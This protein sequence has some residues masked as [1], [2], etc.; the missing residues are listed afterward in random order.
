MDYYGIQEKINKEGNEKSFKYLG[1]E[2]RIIRIDGLGHLCGYVRIPKTNRIY[3]KEFGDYPISDLLVHGGVTFTGNRFDDN[4]WWIGFDCAHFGDLVPGSGYTATGTTYKDMDY[5][6]KEIKN[7]VNQILEFEKKEKYMEN[8]KLDLV[9][10]K[11]SLEVCDAGLEIAANANIFSSMSDLLNIPEEVITEI[12]DPLRKV[13]KQVAADIS[14]EIC[15]QT[16]GVKIEL[17]KDEVAVMKKLL[18]MVKDAKSAQGGDKHG[19]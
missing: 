15:K 16:G 9:T 5:V 18:K 1:Y 14:D 3:K 17:N 19:A 12:I 2:C 8:K 10:V 13:T 6:T 11:I 7:L 4:D